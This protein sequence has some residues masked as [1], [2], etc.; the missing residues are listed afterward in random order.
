V[1]D[2]ICSALIYRKLGFAPA[3][4]NAPAVAGQASSRLNSRPGVIDEEAWKLCRGNKS[5]TQCFFDSPTARYL[6]RWLR[7]GQNRCGTRN[8]GVSSCFEGGI[9]SPAQR[10]LCDVELVSKHVVALEPDN[11]F[12]LTINTAKKLSFPSL[13]QTKAPPPCSMRC[14]SG[15]GSCDHVAP[16]R[17]TRIQTAWPS[18][19]WC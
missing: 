7:Q 3:F 6:G 16:I 9:P 5:M 8:V 1:A 14:Q 4:A 12:P 17:S 11:Q 10:R 15:F 18:A 2:A 19:S 13:P